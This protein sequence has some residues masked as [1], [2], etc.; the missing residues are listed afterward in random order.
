[1]RRA[2]A[3]PALAALAGMPAAQAATVS[4]VSS[5]V[6]IEHSAALRVDDIRYYEV[7]TWDPVESMTLADPVRATTML[8]YTSNVD[9]RLT[10]THEAVAA[11]RI[12]KGLTFDGVLSGPR[13]KV[14]TRDSMLFDGNGFHN[15]S[16]GVAWRHTRSELAADALMSFDLSILTAGPLPDSVVFF[17]RIDGSVEFDLFAP[18]SL[19]GSDNWLSVAAAP[20][21]TST[22]AFAYGQVTPDCAFCIDRREFEFG[23]RNTSLSGEHPRYS[24]TSLLPPQVIAAVFDVHG[25]PTLL[26]LSFG[27]GVES[28]HE[29]WNMEF[30][31]QLL[32]ATIHARRAGTG[33]RRTRDDGRVVSCV[34]PRTAHPGL[35]RHPGRAGAGLGGADA[36]RPAGGR[37]RAAPSTRLNFSAA[38]PA[39]AA[40]GAADMRRAAGR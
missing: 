26:N 23:L 38:G 3:A 17:W 11:G 19:S 40:P 18:S 28:V 15:N 21:M 32:E 34:R 14:E 22:L 12:V 25:D 5:R 39:D 37:H 8:P 9:T 27:L 7:K 4:A 31:N 24:R 35:Q 1:M 2:L 16:E 29:L 6:S 13:L 20:Q 33:R 10:M 36:R 30:A